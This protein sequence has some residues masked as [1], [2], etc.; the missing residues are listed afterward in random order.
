MH[1]SPIDRGKHAGRAR[2]G[3]RAELF[4]SFTW[5]AIQGFGGAAPVAQREL[6]ERKRWLTQQEF[7]ED[8]AVAQIMPGPNVVN[9]SLMLGDRHFGLTGAMA[10]LAGMVTLPLM[11]VL[12]LA[13]IYTQYGHYDVVERALHSMGAVAAGL[14]MGTGFKL[15][16]TLRNN[17]LGLPV[18]LVLIVLTFIVIAL[19]RWPLLWVLLGTGIPAS[20]WAWIRLSHREGKGGQ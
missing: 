7:I 17:P 1:A 10:A 13:I 8:W 9:L 19:L 11:L 5:L 14:I 2:P 12:A 18:A 15:F 16:G 3:S 6:V 4:A 20:L